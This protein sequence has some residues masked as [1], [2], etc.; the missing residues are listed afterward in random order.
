MTTQYPNGIDGDVQIPLTTDNVTPVKAEVINTLRGAIIAVQQELGLNP[1][2]EYATVRQRLDAM[3]AIINALQS[4]GGGGGGNANLTTTPPVNIT[5]STAQLGSIPEAAL[6]DHKHDISTSSATSISSTNSEG[7]STFLARA[8]HTHAVVGLNINSQVQGSILY[9]NGSNWVQLSP[10]TEGY[11]LTTHG[12]GNNPNWQV[13]PTGTTLTA[14]APVNITK[15]T[16]LVGTANDAARSDHKHDI[17]TAAPNSIGNANAEGTSTFL[18]RADHIH[19]LAGTV[20]GNLSG[21]LPNPSV[22]DLT[23]TG[24]SQ[25]SVLYYNGTHWVQLSPGQDGY[26]LTTHS[27]GNNPAWTSLPNGIALAVVAPLDVDK[28]TASVGT[29]ARA[30]HE[31]HKHSASTATAVNIGSTNSEGVATSLAR[32]DHTHAVTDLKFTSQT[33]GDLIYFNGIN[34]VILPPSTDGF[35]LTTH[36]TGLNPSW[37]SLPSGLSLATVTPQNVN[38]S[39]ALI[40]NSLQAAKADHK[41]DIDTA[42]AI[43]IGTVNAEG[44]AAT[45]ARSDHTHQ[46]SNFSITGQTQGDILYYNGTTWAR[47]AA[48]TD[49]NILTTHSIGANPTWSPS[50]SGISLT[51]AAPI[52]VDTSVAVVGVATTAARSDHK[53]NIATAI[54]VSIGTV[55]AQGTSLSLSRSDH[56]HA[57]TG[58]NIASQAQGDLLYFNGTAWVRLPA[59]TAG[60]IL[61]TNSTGANPTWVANTSLSLSSSA[62]VN[63]NVNTAD[64]GVATTAARSDHKHN[65][66]VATAVSIG[67]TNSAGTSTSLSRADHTHAVTNLSISGQTLGDVIYFNGTVWVRLAGGTDGNVLTTHGTAGAPTWNV[68]SS[69]GGSPIT[70]VFTRVGAISAQYNDYSASLIRNDSSVSG[71][72]VTDALNTLSGRATGVSSV[73]G[74]VNAVA[75]QFNDYNSSLIFDSSTIAATTV[76]NALNILNAKVTGVSSVFGRPNAVTAQAGDYNSSQIT[77]SSSAAGTY[78]TDALNTLNARATGV[79]SVFG[80]SGPA[81]IAISGDYK[82]SQIVNDSTYIPGSF[83]SGA[84]DN[85][86]PQ[87]LGIIS[88]TGG[89]TLILSDIGKLIKVTADT[90]SSFSS[91]FT[92]PLQSTVAFPLGAQI[93]FV[94]LDSYSCLFT[95]VSGAVSIFSSLN[96]PSSLA[97]NVQYS[98]FRL[99]YL[100][101]DQWLLTNNIFYSTSQIANSSMFNGGSGNLTSALNSINLQFGGINGVCVPQIPLIGTTGWVGG[102]TSAWSGAGTNGSIGFS[103]P[104]YPNVS[105]N[106]VVINFQPTNGHSSLPSQ[107]P[108]IQV[109]SDGGIV[110]VAVDG[111]TTI[112]FYQSRH[113]LTVTCPTPLNA[114]N[115]GYCSVRINDEAGASPG[116]I[117]GIRLFSLKAFYS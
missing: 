32:S 52:D 61:Q 74:R 48:G 97:N 91:N 13:S 34:W 15:S 42:S 35:V 87:Y 27:A 38:K 84:L 31:D 66:D 90:I 98:L 100:G 18:A 113:S 80:R 78:V 83:V 60:F 28:N 64:V 30:A 92:V 1:A 5:K 10:G 37:V 89:R 43:S 110:G 54:A 112:T 59:S 116:G 104:L 8:D 71:T 73:F 7:S 36:S 19:A 44:I 79:S 41:H 77:N 94:T 11:I 82:A 55:N 40:G 57:V 69:G 93:D 65:I 107:M 102:I 58:L 23:I 50:P 16:A 12:T 21:T 33:Q 106:S 111:S 72:T 24:A 88:N 105:L 67:A 49:G 26:V 108:F 75:A 29:S 25:G 47:L 6:S 39:T 14:N 85:L 53:H 62:P 20:G 22:V 9:Y 2:R 45:L 99:T 86:A 70:S 51:N 103:I 17:S 117:Q 109:Y 63:V 3:Q 46:V 95:P 115:T 96:A 76:T 81:I 101:S 68:P 4:S 114:T 56:T